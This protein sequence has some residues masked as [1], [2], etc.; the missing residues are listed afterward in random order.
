MSTQRPKAKIIVDGREIETDFGV[1]S[2]N[3]A[4]APSNFRGDSR[5]KEGDKVEEAS[6]E[7]FPASDAPNY[8]P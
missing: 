4:S 3:L 1:S 8:R 2:E 6:D 7:S 5:L